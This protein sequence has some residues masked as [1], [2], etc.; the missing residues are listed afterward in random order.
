M[1]RYHLM[2]RLTRRDFLQ[3]SAALA[4]AC[5]TGGLLP[6]RSTAQAQNNP[7]GGANERL[8]VA[9]IGVRGRGRDHVTGFAGRN[10]CVVTHLCDAD[11]AV[12]GPAMTAAERQQQRRPEY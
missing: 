7:G 1:A 3:G 2:Q 5:A 12:A 11:S 9:V 8:N 4:A 10:N 6:D